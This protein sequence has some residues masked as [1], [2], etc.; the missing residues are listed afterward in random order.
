MTRTAFVLSGG[1]SLGAVQVG[2]L[3]ALAERDIQPDLYVGSSVGALN[4]CFASL[5]PGGD[6]VE[7]LAGLWRSIRGWQVFPP[8]PLEAMLGLVGLRNAL[9]SSDP[10]R[11]LIRDRVGDTRLEDLPTP[12]LCIATSVLSG[13]T[14]ELSEGSA[15]DAAAASSAIPGIYPPVSIDGV[16]L[17][18]GGVSDNTPLDVAVRLG[19]RTVYVLPTGFACAIAS[20]PSGALGM[21]I[22]AL[23]VLV[24]QRLINDVR[25]YEPDIELVVLPPPC[26]L[27]VVPVDFSHT[28][29]LIA[30]GY[31]LAKRRLSRRTPVRHQA[32]ALERRHARNHA[33]ERGD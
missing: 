4:S 31:E 17:M 23:S 10:L 32:D 20:P 30:A 6:G 33:L 7:K 14:A 24:E 22:H 2:M 29:E 26:P 9:V 21:A 19:A 15:A 13:R 27:T 11:A 18:D 1:A 5:H 3:K 8:L 12:T 25:R 16:P 28:E